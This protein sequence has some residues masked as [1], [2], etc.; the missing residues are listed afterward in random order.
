MAVIQNRI[1]ISYRS[2][3]GKKDANRLAEDLGKVFGDDQ[4]FFDK[5]DL[6]GGS[7]WREEIFAAIGSR[8]VVLLVLTPDYFGAKFP[9]GRLRLDEADDPVRQEL[10]ATIQIKA[11]IMPLL[12]EGVTMPS[13]GS[14]PSELRVVTEK[15]ALR[16]RTDDWKN[17][18]L[19]IIDDLIRQGVKPLRE[20][21]RALF[22]GG[23]GA[24]SILATKPKF[25]LLWIA[26]GLLILY[27]IGV[28]EEPDADTYYGMA[29][30]TLIP[31]YLV[32]RAYG[33]LKFSGNLGKYASI[34]M[35]V[36][37]GWEILSFTARGMQL[38]KPEQQAITTP[39]GSITPTPM[40]GTEP[41]P[42]PIPIPAKIE[43]TASDLSGSWMAVM[44]NSQTLPFSI[45]HKAESITFTTTRISVANDPWFQTINLA[46]AANGGLVI[47]DIRMRGGGSIFEREIEAEIAL[48]SGDG[49]R[50]IDSGNM[51]LVVSPDGKMLSGSV[52]FSSGQPT[53]LRFVRQ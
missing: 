3:D 43:S 28:A 40:T 39:P 32:W 47:Q 48:T 9:D 29:M 1:F 26:L 7:S 15:H 31:L 14:L 33:K 8:P 5:H 17:D 24:D 35:L 2:S 44:A 16:L 11:T 34:A 4:V 45:I 19:R 50:L 49:Q 18:L 51:S 6:R 20:D 42:A 52:H 25:T 21:W 53:P 30:L 36:I 46:L 38:A 13:A 27:E 41:A 23:T 22:G 12:G 37:T 10:G